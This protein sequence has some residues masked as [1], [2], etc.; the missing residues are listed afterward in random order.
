L[1]LVV[2]V[3]ASWGA[4]CSSR[5][6]IEGWVEA[7][8]A[9][10]DVLTRSNSPTCPE[11]FAE[12]ERHYAWAHSHL[13]LTTSDRVTYFKYRDLSDLLANA[14]CEEEDLSPP[15]S[16]CAT[17]GSVQ[18]FEPINEHELMHAYTLSHWQMPRF[19]E[20]GIAVAA[21]C[22]VYL[23]PPS[24]AV[25]WQT[26]VGM[27]ALP[28]AQALALYSS[29]GQFVAALLRQEGGPAA[30]AAL[31][32]A[33]P[34]AD[35]T[36]EL[37]GVFAATTGQDLDTFWNTTQQAGPSAPA[38]ESA[39]QCAL[40]LDPGGSAWTDDCS[41]YLVVPTSAA[42]GLHVT[43]TGN[44]FTTIGC[45]TGVRDDISFPVTPGGTPSDNWIMPG[46]HDLAARPEGS[47]EA[48]EGQNAN[49]T[50][51]LLQTPWATPTCGAGVTVPLPADRLTYLDFSASTAP[52]YVTLAA[53]DMA[54]SFSFGTYSTGN[55]EAAICSSCAAEPSDCQP[56]DFDNGN[57]VILQGTVVLQ[58]SSVTTSIDGGWATFNFI[59]EPS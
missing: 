18:A 56:L 26:L 59:P 52:L 41:P 20:E 9:S 3:A 16:G 10:F 42:I 48:G 24:G 31:V 32:A 46:A 39:W 45:G 6:P 55:L 13:G 50:A 23:S 58:I 49:L 4:G 5:T 47:S 1:V 37:P 57:P 54:T 38:C 8:S 22:P 17:A 53:P 36:T 44:S 19:I 15:D 34:F 25:T 51:E 30:L 35:P 40:P 33:Y 14:T 11:F 2:G 29:A 12:A 43:A 27:D 28:P 7:S 21:T